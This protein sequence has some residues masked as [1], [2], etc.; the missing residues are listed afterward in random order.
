MPPMF[1]TP[2][3]SIPANNTSFTGASG[4][5][6]WENSHGAH[7]QATASQWRLKIGRV[8]NSWDIY[9][10]IGNPF[11][12]IGDN[13]TNLN[14]DPS[15]SGLPRDGFWYWVCPEYSNDGGI[16]WS[17]GAWTRFKSL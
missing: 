17:P 10:G 11:N 1:A 12:V 8:Q 15:V 16:N 13:G 4:T 2:A 14:I 7:G 3:V 9:P 6:K 5:F